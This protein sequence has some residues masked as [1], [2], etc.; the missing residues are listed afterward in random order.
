M[1][2]IFD[3]TKKEIEHTIKTAPQHIPPRLRLQKK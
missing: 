2:G 1:S 3:R